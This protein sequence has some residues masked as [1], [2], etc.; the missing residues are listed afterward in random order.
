M[1]AVW[2]PEYEPLSILPRATSY[3]QAASG[4]TMTA[5]STSVSINMIMKDQPMLRKGKV[6]EPASLWHKFAVVSSWSGA[7]AGD[8]HDGPQVLV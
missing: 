7:H 5:R 1:R 3:S 8:M 4:A 6:S 2:A